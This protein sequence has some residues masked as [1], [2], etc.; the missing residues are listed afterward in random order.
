MRH[1]FYD[2][3]SNIFVYFILFCFYIITILFGGSRMNKKNRL[4]DHTVP[5]SAGVFILGERPIHLI[6]KHLMTITVLSGSLIITLGNRDSE[7]AEGETALIPCDTPVTIRISQDS[8]SVLIIGVDPVYFRDQF[9]HIESAIFD[10]TKSGTDRKLLPLLLDCA[11]A[12]AERNPEAHSLINENIKASLKIAL[13]DG[14]YFSDVIKGNYSSSQTQMEY[15]VLM[16]S[17]LQY[18]SSNHTEK[19]SLADFAHKEHLSENYMSHLIKKIS[20]TTF[21]ELLSF[22]RCKKAEPMLLDP[23]KRINEIAYAAGF[24]APSYFKSS[25]EKYYKVTPDEYRSKF[26]SMDCDTVLPDECTVLDTKKMLRDFATKHN[27]TLT[28]TTD[29]FFTMDTVYI[30]HYIEHFQKVLSDEGPINNIDAEMNESSHAAFID[31]QKEF[32]MNIITLDASI[33]M[34]KTATGHQLTIA[35]N[36]NYLIWS[37]FRIRFVIY[38]L[39][40]NMI[41]AIIRFMK[42][43]F[44]RFNETLDGI[45]FMIRVNAPED[46]LTTYKINLSEKLREEIGPFF[47]VGIDPAYVPDIQYFSSLYDSFVLAPF[48]MDELFHPENWKIGIDF[49]LIDAVSE[50]GIILSGG[51]GLLTWNGIKKPWWHAY[52]LASKL[53]GSIVSKG[54]DHIITNNSGIITILT[55]NTCGLPPAYLQS[56]KTKQ[57]LYD[58]IQNKGHVREHAF[59]L[60]NMFGKYKIIRYTV[61]ET[62]CLFS[63][64]AALEYPEFLTLEEETVLSQICH[65]EVNFSTTDSNGRIDITTREESFGVT[66][67]VL[68]KI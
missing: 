60:M 13:D 66:C 53:K 67:V 35:T 43:Y 19:I 54:P 61:N 8:T 3:N 65:P 1:Q 41:S 63:K 50:D 56:L 47:N 45:D 30:D 5:I 11:F 39:S 23:N 20:G 6:P 4:F 17:I 57:E 37:K 55:Y 32:R 49:S 29:R 64:W 15:T 16:Q 27:I 31:M 10:K 46:V 42:F 34:D 48:A 44:R 36:I 51:C 9:P 25:F 58:A 62:S 12:L 38:S 40:S 14:Q 22:V 24:S 7:Y 52:N 33:L 68:E 18:I 26:I 59:Q 28:I 21:K 2:R